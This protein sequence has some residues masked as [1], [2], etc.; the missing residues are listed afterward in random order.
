MGPSELITSDAY[1]EWMRARVRNAS[2]CIHMYMDEQHPNVDINRVY[3]LQAKLNLINP[4][5]F[6]LLPLQTTEWKRAF[7]EARSREMRLREKLKI[8]QAHSGMTFHLKPAFELDLAV[9]QQKIN[10]DEFRNE[11][12]DFYANDSMIQI[13]GIQQFEKG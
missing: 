3:R 5:Y 7:E 10:N 1:L 2:R 4:E 6:K 13:D 9:E 11:I 8:V 12:F